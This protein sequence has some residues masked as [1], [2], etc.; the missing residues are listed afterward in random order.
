MSS[1]DYPWNPM[2]PRTIERAAQIKQERQRV[3]DLPDPDLNRC[4]RCNGLKDPSDSI[5]HDC[6]VETMLP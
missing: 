5:C 1:P 6:A 4:S 2:D 3:R